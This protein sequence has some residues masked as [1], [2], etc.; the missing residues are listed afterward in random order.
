MGL[1]HQR[2]CQPQLGGGVSVAPG[3]AAPVLGGPDAAA[4][5]RSVT[6]VVS[7]TWTT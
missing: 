1:T 7:I 4:L 5:L 2:V 3:E 6:G